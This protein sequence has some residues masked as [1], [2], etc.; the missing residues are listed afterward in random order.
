MVKP[1][2]G[3]VRLKIKGVYLYSC[4]I[5]PRMDDEFGAILD[6]IVT[7]AKERSPVAI[8]GDFNAWSVEWGSKKTNWS[9]QS[10]LEAFSVLDLQLLNDG[11]LPMHVDDRSHIHEQ[12]P[13][14][15]KLQ[16]G[17]E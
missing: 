7:D 12:L 14:K 8:A 9:E 4:Y 2:L 13:C 10:L 11:G 5:P 3:L 17:S 15:R 6:R 1:E 16:L